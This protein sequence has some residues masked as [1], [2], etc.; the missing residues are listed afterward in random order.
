MGGSHSLFPGQRGCGIQY[1]PVQHMCPVLG[2]SAQQAAVSVPSGVVM[3]NP[4]DSFAA[5]FGMEFPN[6]GQPRD[7]KSYP[8]IGLLIHKFLLCLF[9]LIFAYN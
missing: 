6:S 7:Y 2:V 9:C 1:D 4:W 8:I 5:G 3:A